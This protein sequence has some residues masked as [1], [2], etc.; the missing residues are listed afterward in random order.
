MVVFTLSSD[1][2]SVRFGRS[3]FGVPGSLFEPTGVYDGCSAE[4]NPNLNTNADERT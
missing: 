3:M 4:R 2:F 1:G